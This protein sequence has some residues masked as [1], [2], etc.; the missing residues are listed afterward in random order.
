MEQAVYEGL[1]KCDATAHV[2]PD[3]AQSFEANANNTQFTFK[4]RPNVTFSDGTKV[5]AAAVET[6]IKHLQTGG[7]TKDRLAAVAVSTPDDSTVVLT[8]PKSDPVLLTWLCQSYI[9]SPKYLESGDLNQSPVGTGPYVLSKEGT[10]A[11]SVYTFTRRS[12]YWDEK[13]FPHK[14]LVVKVMPDPTATVNALRS[15]QV[16]AA[17]VNTSTVNQ[18]KS[19]GMELVELSGSWAGLIIADRQ[20]AKVPALGNVDVRRAMNMVFDRE[21]IAKS[22]YNGSATPTGQIFRK[23]SNAWLPDVDNTYPYDIEAAKKL[24]AKAGYADGFTIDVPFIAGYGW[25]AAMPMVIQQLGEI[26]IKVNQV[27]L[28]GPNAIPD[29]IGGTYPLI[30]WPLGNGGNSFT[31]ITTNLAPTGVWNVLHQTDPNLQPL[32][33]KSLVATGDEA[34]KLQQQ[35]NQ[36]TI[37]QAWFAPIVYPANYTAY[38][39]KSTTVKESTDVNGLN[40]NLRDFS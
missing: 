11:G 17:P 12:D 40:P 18:A 15:G 22:L 21:Q 36:Y 25:D 19:N 27:T 8:V 31:D 24:M 6:A 23:G 14:K 13:A 30:F 5:D 38:N 34:A 16:D 9:A 39:P 26:N 37:D 20:G 35:I 4:L 10:T 2:T 3:L 29:L 7:S 28:T 1:V 33:D 32:I